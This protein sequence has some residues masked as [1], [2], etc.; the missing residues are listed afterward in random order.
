MSNHPIFSWPE[1]N[2]FPDVLNI[3]RYF[4]NNKLAGSCRMGSIFGLLPATVSPQILQYPLPAPPDLRLLWTFTIFN[5]NACPL[6][7]KQSFCNHNQSSN[8]FYGFQPIF[9]SLL[10]FLEDW[11]EV[12]LSLQLTLEKCI[13]A[14]FDYL[15]LP[16]MPIDTITTT[17]CC[18][19]F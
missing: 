16:R 18:Y 14:K 19:L 3:A 7:Y 11:L 1:T 2:D 10:F 6:H 13:S 4:T 17:L 12:V 5:L 8:Q 9:Q 15:V